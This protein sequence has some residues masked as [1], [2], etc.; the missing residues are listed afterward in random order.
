MASGIL[1]TG[2]TGGIGR[3]LVRI[4]SEKGITVRAG[5]HTESK[6]NRVKYPQVEMVKLNFEDITS[7][8]FSL[9]GIKTLFLLTPIAR[10]Q[11]EYARRMIDRAKLFGVEHIVNI[12]IMSSEVEPGTQITRWHRRIERYLER[13][14]IAFTIVKPNMYMQNFLRFMQPSG[15]I[16]FLPLNDAAVS[17]V[18]VRDIARFSAA[19]ILEGPIH[20]GKQYEVTGPAALSIDSVADIISCVTRQHVGYIPLQEQTA[21]HV[22]ESL[23][24]PSWMAVG[25]LELYAQQRIGLNNRVSKVIDAITGIPAVS[26]EQFVY[27]HLEFFKCI[28]NR[29]HQ[30]YLS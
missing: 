29:E 23:G 16:I 19:I 20:Y 6:S 27:D 3:N 22:M 26:F 11:V 12:S 14:D 30:I 25:M 9:Q 24:I 4:L 17:Y 10:E 2:A 21:R 18:D 28:I 7:I 13:I 15:G 8:D 1:I 5:I